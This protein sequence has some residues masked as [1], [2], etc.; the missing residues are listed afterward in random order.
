MQIKLIES[1]IDEY[2]R[3]IIQ[4][5]R[6]RRVYQQNRSQ[7]NES[8]ANFTKRQLSHL[9]PTSPEDSASCLNRK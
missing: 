9:N 8:E 6:D 5:N 7:K 1:E 4:K 3:Q 2:K